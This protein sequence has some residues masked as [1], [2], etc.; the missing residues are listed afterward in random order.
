MGWEERLREF[1]CHRCGNCCRGD[2]YV[3]LTQADIR[4]IAEHLG[5]TREEFLK[6][7]TRMAEGKI[8][9]LDKPGPDMWCM[10][11]EP[12]LG[13]RVNAVKPWQCIGFPTKWHDEDSIDFC[14]GLQILAEGDEV[15]TSAGQ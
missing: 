10:F 14:K 8:A 12:G 11:Y 9:L 13:C 6:T 2:G 5:L 4:R 7:H 1:V 3:W 15:E